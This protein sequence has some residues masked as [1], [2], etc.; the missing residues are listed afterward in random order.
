MTSPQTILG[1]FTKQLD[2][3]KYK[4]SAAS[5][6]VKSTVAYKLYEEVQI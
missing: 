6:H 3:G 1:R 4:Q 5:M 2:L